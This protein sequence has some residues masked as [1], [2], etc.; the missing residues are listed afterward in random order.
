M[1]VIRNVSNLYKFHDSFLAYW[2]MILFHKYV[3]NKY[4][5]TL[6]KINE[7]YTYATHKNIVL[8]TVTLRH[9]FFFQCRQKINLLQY[10]YLI[11]CLT[12]IIYYLRH[13][14]EFVEKY[15]CIEDN[16]FYD[17]DFRELANYRF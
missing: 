17:Q 9:S 15:K 5:T 1:V 11:F 13:E 3:I 10:K 14:N 16:I 8:Q 2:I 7:L 6:L 12:R 4:I